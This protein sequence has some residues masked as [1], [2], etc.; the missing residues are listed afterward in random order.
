MPSKN[1]SGDGISII[2]VL[3]DFDANQ[4]CV[5]ERDAPKSD[6]YCSCHSFEYK[7]YLCRHAIVVLHMSG[8]FNIPSNYIL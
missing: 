4:N 7:G 8:V 2:Y 3:K 1:E 5:V 6:T